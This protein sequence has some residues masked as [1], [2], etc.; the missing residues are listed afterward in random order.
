M[1]D[2]VEKILLLLVG[3]AIGALAYHFAL[4]GSGCN[5]PRPD[6]PPPIT[7]PPDT[8]NH[9]FQPITMGGD[10]PVVPPLTDDEIARFDS[11]RMVIAQQDS[12]LGA[13]LAKA[14]A[15]HI[16]W[17]SFE[18]TSWDSVFYVK[19]RLRTE[20][21]PLT[22]MRAAILFL[23]TVRVLRPPPPDTVFVPVI[24]RDSTQYETGYSLETVLLVGAVSAAVT[25]T[26]IAIA[27]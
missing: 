1:R 15:W 23:D 22:R 7:H 19:G 6:V 20:Q 17:W 24:V 5:A 26:G 2:T 21:Y 4:R 8:G 27:R 12:V 14:N 3:V 9:P 11:L 16:D 25:A 18:D 13:V 10:G